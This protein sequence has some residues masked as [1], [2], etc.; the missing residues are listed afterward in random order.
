MDP[1]E[2]ECPGRG[3]SESDSAALAPLQQEFRRVT[4]TVVHTR[5]TVTDSLRPGSLRERSSGVWQV[6][7][8]LGRDP[9]TRATGRRRRRCEGPS[10]TP[11]GLRRVW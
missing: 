6:R 3:S 11:S 9:A 8:S 4:R 2:V 1:G 10:A 5:A 7:V